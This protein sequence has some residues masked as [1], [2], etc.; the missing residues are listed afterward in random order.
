MSAQKPPIDREAIRAMVRQV[1]RDALPE[2]VRERIAAEAAK[3][4]VSAPPTPRK[5]EPTAHPAET[6]AARIEEV[7]ITTDA[8]LNVFV[9]RLLALEPKQREAVQAGRLKFRLQRAR[10]SLESDGAPRGGSERIDKGIV[11]ERKVVAAAKA[12]KRLVVGKGVVL[13]PLAR[14][15]ARQ[16]G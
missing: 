8:E 10:K 14:D 12:G 11:N 7:A 9:R 2:S 13:T 1:L 3:A 16:L 5:S 15:K 6:E 4:A